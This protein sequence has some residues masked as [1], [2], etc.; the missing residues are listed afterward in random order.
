VCYALLLIAVSH[1]TPTL[2]TA[3]LLIA[4]SP[5]LMCSHDYT[6]I[7]S[8]P[9]SFD[10]WHALSSGRVLLDLYVQ[11]QNTEYVVLKC[12]TTFCYASSDQVSSL[13]QCLT[14]LL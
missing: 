14:Q 13:V 10:V 8:S 12:S 9:F 4:V 7:E 11:M 5:V 3:L 2:C 1:V 6:S